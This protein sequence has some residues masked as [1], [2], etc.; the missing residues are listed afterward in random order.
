MKSDHARTNYS[1]DQI[2]EFASRDLI[3]GSRGGSLYSGNVCTSE[4]QYYIQVSAQ[5]NSG[6]WA[7]GNRNGTCGLYCNFNKELHRFSKTG[8]IIGLVNSYNDDDSMNITLLA[9]NV[10]ITKVAYL[11]MYYYYVSG[12]N[13]V[14][15]IVG[16]IQSTD[17]PSWTTWKNYRPSGDVSKEL[18]CGVSP[19]GLSQFITFDNAFDY[20]PQWVESTFNNYSFFN[21]FCVYRGQNVNAQYHFN[22]TT[23]ITN[24]LK[25]GVGKNLYATLGEGSKGYPAL[26]MGDEIYQGLAGNI[27]EMMERLGFELS[28]CS[29]RAFDT[30]Y[31]EYAPLGVA[32]F[33]SFANQ[34]KPYNLILTESKGQALE[35]I[36]TGR[37]PSDAWIYP[38]ETDTTKFPREDP[39]GDPDNP[40]DYPD[41]NNP[42]DDT[43]DGEPNPPVV[44]A[45]TPT[46]LSNNNYY[47]LTKA[48][49]DDFFDWFWN[50]VGELSDFDDIIKKVEGL[51]ND[52]AS[53]V[54]NVRYMPI[55][56]QYIGGLGADSN[57]I[58]GM[59][60]KSGAVNTLG[61]NNPTVRDIGNIKIPDKYDS[62]LDLSPYSSMSLYLPYHGFIDLDI[63]M[64]CG[65]NLYVKAIYDHISGTIQYLLYLD[66]AFL[67]NTI[68][69]KMAVDIPF[70]LQSKAD[71]DSAIFNNVTNAV[72][73]LIG[74]GMSVASGNPI[75]LVYGAQAINQTASAPM[76]TYGNVGESGAFYAPPKCAIVVRRPTI[77]K[78]R[79]WSS[80]CGYLSCYTYKLGDLTGFTK[81]H[82]PRITFGR[83]ENSNQGEEAGTYYTV[84]PYPEEIHEIYDYLEKGVIL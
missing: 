28:G 11:T 81:C 64:F 44:P 84:N 37:L 26:R 67:I 19:A 38:C 74:A 60:E 29:K 77:A 35:Y 41:N 80:I 4:S 16:D 63:N 12:G 18:Q 68:V 39:I 56:P 71:R 20:T 30:S 54:L 75:G 33:E 61:R 59:I 32:Q 14:I 46:Q 22:I 58:V 5:T 36:R 8:R 7:Y 76:K 27:Y 3:I 65:H 62:F 70:T 72:G 51:Y 15:V 79:N 78:P 1:Q 43:F 69:A 66:N 48:Q 73:G 42:D 17:Y 83:A 82:Q 49:L 24:T 9:D 25:M 13:D 45:T 57:I 10:E 34:W 40:D 21:D 2:L 50:D 6:A 53:A 23:D 31:I 52:L 47:W 55:Q